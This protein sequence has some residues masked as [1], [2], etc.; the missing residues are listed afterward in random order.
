MKK[1]ITNILPNVFLFAPIPLITVPI[2]SL[3]HKLEKNFIIKMWAVL[4]YCFSVLLLF[5]NFIHTG[6]LYLAEMLILPLVFLAGLTPF[7]LLGVIY[8]KRQAEKI[9]KE[10]K[11]NAEKKL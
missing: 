2:S 6:F 10:E 9:I 5:G 7:I 4:G 8:G 3:W 11:E 1:H